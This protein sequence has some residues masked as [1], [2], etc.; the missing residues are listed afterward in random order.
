MSDHP[1]PIAA[2]LPNIHAS[3]EKNKGVVL[4]AE[5]GAGKSTLLPLSLLDKDFLRGGRIIM[6]EP[7]RV[8]A[9]SI[10]HYLA[11]QLGE[12][13]GQTIGYQVRNDR[14]Q[15]ARHPFRNRYRRG[16]NAAPPNRSRII[17]GWL[18]DLR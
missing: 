8:A 6:L 14:K 12:E 2:Q 13:V 10:A 5:P 18:G 1:L 7:R 11:R 3:I 17:G 15:S 9:R 16:L 4:Q